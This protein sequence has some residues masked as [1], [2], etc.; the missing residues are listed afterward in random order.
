MKGL[1]V[2]RSTENTKKNMFIFA[3]FFSLYLTLF[4]GKTSLPFILLIAFTMILAEFLFGFIRSGTTLPYLLIIIS[5]ITLISYSTLPDFKIR[6]LTLILFAYVVTI[7]F[8]KANILKKKSIPENKPIL[9]WIIPFVLFAALSIWLDYKGIHLSGDEPHYLMITQSI[10]ED[11]DILL[12]NNVEN[13]TYMDFIPVELPA[14]MII[15]NGKHLSFHMPG[16]SILLIP[17]YLLFKI[18]GNIISPQLFFRISISIINAFF[19]FALFYLA[20]SIFPTKKIINIWLLSILTVPMLF[21]S[22]HIFPELP[23]STLL[24]GSF[25]LIIRNKTNS[26]LAGFMY[27][28]TIWFHVKYYPLLLLFGLYVM[29]N[30]LKNRDKKVFLKFFVFPALSSILL[31]LFCKLTYGTYNPTGI[32]PS[33]NYLTTPM[34]LKIKVFFAYFLDQRDGLLF[35]APALFLFIFGFKKIK[36][37]LKLP[38]ILLITYTIFHSI[39]TVRGAYSPAGR[40]L[41]FVLWIILLFTYNHYFNSNRKYLFTILSGLNF[42][43]LFWILYYPQFIYQPVFASTS[44]GTSSLLRFMSSN[45]VNISSLFPS[46][47][48]L[49]KYLY[50]PNLVWIVSLFTVF[51]IY[52]LKKSNETYTSDKLKKSIS[53]IVFTISTLSLSVLPH[54]MISAKDNFRQKGISFFNTSANFVRIDNEREFRIKSNEEYSLYFE[55]RKWKKKICFEFKVPLGSSLTVMNGKTKIL[56]RDIAGIHRL[57]IDLSKMNKVISKNRILIPIWIKTESCQKSSFFY[58]NIKSK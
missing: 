9:I 57:N 17:F 11:G 49:R 34:L 14:H 46:F 55:E 12:K 28:L 23:A 44:L 51:L 15:R 19:P 32:F 53:I 18:T 3:G 21:H 58:L 7:P 31:I 47:L 1:N 38:A 43:V 26:L 54:I 16:L 5:P 2:L 40:P 4:L 6:I 45:I 48:T 25:I 39:T 33:E 10:V 35:Y 20:K 50:S 41:I 37:S 36:P 56:D 30:L 24:V 13:K 52:H 29:W 22:I 27:S 42:F 8:C